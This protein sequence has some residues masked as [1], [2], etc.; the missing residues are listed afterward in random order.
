MTI[1]LSEP[2]NATYLRKKFTTGASMWRNMSNPTLAKTQC[3][4]ILGRFL[5]PNDFRVVLATGAGDS[6]RL[7]E[8]AEIVRAALKDWGA[9]SI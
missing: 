6:H 4:N 5:D 1:N 7:E 9:V 3:S 8:D 2:S